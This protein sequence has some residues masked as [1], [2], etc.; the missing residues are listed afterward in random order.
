MDATKQSWQAVARVDDV[1][2]DAPLEVP[3][4]NAVF[5]LVRGD[6]EIIAYQGT[7][8]HAAARLGGGRVIDGWL[9]C[10]HHMA[11][12]RLSDGVCGKGWVLPALRRYAVKVEDGVVH[13]S[14][15]PRPVLDIVSD[16]PH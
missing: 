7:C 11:M 5:I 14:N 4:G 1:I 8:P 2:S 3:M 6:D 9:R 10:P 15:P 13:M 16:P 12:F